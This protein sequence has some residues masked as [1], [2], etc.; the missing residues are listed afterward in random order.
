MLLQREGNHLRIDIGANS[1]RTDLN[2]N[3]TSSDANELKN[4]GEHVKGKVLDVNQNTVLISSGGKEFLATSTVPMEN[5]IGEEM[6]FNIF[7]NDD[8]SVLLKPDMQKKELNLVK[9]LK[10]E[11]LLN[12]L[13]QP[14][15][16]EN[17][18]ILKEMIKAGIPVTKESFKE[19]K[20]L[21]ISLKLVKEEDFTLISNDKLKLPLDELVKQGIEKSSKTDV[22]QNS[23]SNMALKDILFLKSANITVSAQNIKALSEIYQN[24]K[25]K[26]IDLIGLEKLSHNDKENKINQS[27][28]NKEDLTSNKNTQVSDISKEASFNKFDEISKIQTSNKIGL[29]SKNQDTEKNTLLK[30]GSS[31]NQ[32]LDKIVNLIKD[33]SIKNLDLEK[34]HQE[35]NPIKLDFE[36]IE[37]NLKLLMDASKDR[38]DIRDILEKDI[39]PKTELL[40][41]FTKDL[42]FHIVPFEIKKYENIAQYYVKKN[43]KREEND[44]LRIGFSIDTYKN[45]NVRALLTYKNESTMNIDMYFENKSIESKFKKLLPKLDLAI[46]NLGYSNI[47]LKTQIKLEETG[48]LIEEASYK[49]INLE[50]F[51]TWV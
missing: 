25:D 16:G 8:G 47:N 19:I 6:L 44:E 31:E 41:N 12:T 10:L 45:G 9:E 33:A 36:K 26:N 20:D 7:I 32:N 29:D 27:F 18:E 11:D 48:P 5:F 21:N 1:F 4:R 22:H 51:E 35:K 42:S 24:I 15:T 40:K 43:K 34:N 23:I 17:K 50:T 28:E 2:L 49:N 3:K 39:L 46:K 30:S 13:K 38:K 14:I 37:D